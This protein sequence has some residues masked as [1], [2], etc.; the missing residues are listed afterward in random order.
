MPHLAGLVDA[1]TWWAALDRLVAVA[2]QSA[3]LP[4]AGQPLLHQLLAGELPLALG[5]L[6]P[7]LRCSTPLLAQARAALSTGLIE[8]LDQGIPHGQHFPVFRPLVACWTRSAA[9]GVQLPKSFCSRRAANQYAWAVRQAVNLT[10]ASGGYPFD[11]AESD[12][13]FPPLI[14]AA[15]SLGG[16]DDDRWI[17]AE[18]LPKWRKPPTAEPKRRPSPALH[19]EWAS[20][21]VLR[22]TWS[23]RDPRLTVLYPGRDVRLEL[24]AARQPLFSGVWDL[25]VVRD[26]QTLA[27]VSHWAETCWVSDK[28]VDYL[29]LEADLGGGVRVERHL[30]FAREDRF[31]FLADAVFSDRP[32]ELEYRGR[33]PLADIA[34]AHEADET[35]EVTL[36]AGKPA[37]VAMPLALPEWR[38]D[39]RVGHAAVAERHLELRQSARGSGLFAP[40]FIDLDPRRLPRPATWRQLTV[41]EN[42]NA[43]PPEV[44]VGY[45]VMAGRRQWLL[46]RTLGPL[47]N[48]T[49]LGHNL[50]TQLLIARFGADGEIEPL[51]EIE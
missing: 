49:L 37:A 2:R 9:M 21:G 25:E 24:E 12:P 39:P 10:R 4:L 48:R 41:A 31:L 26:G 29:E 18:A 3:M 20:V 46:Y 32:A 28:D 6:F 7:E 40:W 33:L 44:A 22:P 23:R 27:P 45:R 8:L 11:S 19:S 35:R 15:L 5:Y 50:V 30:A 38:V 14:Q 16:D 47:G 1:A 36:S 13:T 17:A 43:V 51:V 34:A 42:R